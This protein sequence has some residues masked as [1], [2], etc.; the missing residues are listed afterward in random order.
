MFKVG[1]RVPHPCAFFAQGWDATKLNQQIHQKRQPQRKT[2]IGKS[3]AGR[4]ILSPSFWRKGEE[5]HI[6]TSSFVKSNS[7]I[8]LLPRETNRASP[9]GA[10]G[11]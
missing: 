5:T 11:K 10:A 9:G 7:P 1:G 3:T 2:A 8:E 4:P 6:S